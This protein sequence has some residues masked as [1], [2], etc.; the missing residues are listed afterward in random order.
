MSARLG[1]PQSDFAC[2][3]ASAV[4]RV[5]SSVPPS[6]KCVGAV[7]PGG[8]RAVAAPQPNNPSS[9]PPRRRRS[10]SRR[11]TTTRLIAAMTAT[12]NI[13]AASGGPAEPPEPSAR[14]PRATL[15]HRPNT[16]S[17]RRRFS[18]L[19]ACS[20]GSSHERHHPR[21]DT[22][23]TAAREM[24][25]VD[26]R[27]RSP[28]PWDPWRCSV[29]PGTARAWD[30]PAGRPQRLLSGYPQVSA[31]ACRSGPAVRGRVSR[32]AE[33]LAAP[34]N[35]PDRHLARVRERHV[36]R[37]RARTELLQLS[38]DL[39]TAM[40]AVEGRTRATLDDLEPADALALLVLARQRRRGAPH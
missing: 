6:T 36:R 31:R 9:V 32:T 16:A 38:S 25:T 22:P 29:G 26:R 24:S 23:G 5:R 11:W 34:Y 35:G 8:R 30:V 17:T 18:A 3:R 19:R 4:G 14:T 1:S 7:R 15:A 27:G 13:I 39:L 20:C 33:R 2:R 10:V 21:P 12:T 28:A 40:L 37:S